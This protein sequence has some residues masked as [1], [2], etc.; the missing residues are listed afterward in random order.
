LR[1]G[2]LRGLATTGKKRS[3]LFPDM[4]TIGEFYPD[5]DVSIWLGVFAPAATAESV[6]TRLRAEVR[7][8][9]G[10]G[11]FVEKLN[12]TGRLEPLDLSPQEFVALIRKDYDK[13]G[14]LVKDVGVQP[15]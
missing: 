7:K 13:Y 14:K 8:A 5:Y 6:L 2:Q 10:Q 15:E 11:D 4:P 12:V 9:L 3:P 1:A